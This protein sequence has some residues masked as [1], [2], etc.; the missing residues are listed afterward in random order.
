[1]RILDHVLNDRQF[2]VD[3]IKIDV[4]GG[5]MDVLKGSTSL[6]AQDK[7]MLIFEFGKGA[8]E[9]YGT[10]PHHMFE[11]LD[12]YNYSIRTL[13]G[14]WKKTTAL[15]SEQLKMIYESG[16]DYYFVANYREA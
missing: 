11:L 12:A 5:E 16:S 13:E 6:L 15:D 14:F 10:M 7:P 8:S 1:V 3:L 2:S 9:Y 4:E